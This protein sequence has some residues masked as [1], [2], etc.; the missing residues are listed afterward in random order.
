[1]LGTILPSTFYSQKYVTLG[2]IVSIASLAAIVFGGAIFYHKD[3]VY[4]PW[5]AGVYAGVHRSAWSLCVA[6]IAFACIKGYGGQ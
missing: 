4:N 6:W 3:H 1:M 2:W 5:E